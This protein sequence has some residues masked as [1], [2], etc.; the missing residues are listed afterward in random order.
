GSLEISHTY[1]SA[2]AY[3]VSVTISNSLGSA[4]IW[5]VN[6]MIVTSNPPT[7]VDLSPSDITVPEIAGSI[8]FNLVRSGNLNT[9]ATVHY[10]HSEFSPV[11]VNQ[12]EAIGGD[13]TFAPGETM[14][15]FKMR[16]F[17]DHAYSDAVT[18]W[19]GVTA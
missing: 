2:G 18:G 5:I 1:A 6:P 19:V 7:F 10:G 13:I 17:D 3:H 4:P 14:K 16:I 8:T 11:P 12:G 15:S 9:T